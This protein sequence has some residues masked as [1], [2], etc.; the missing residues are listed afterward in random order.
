MTQP[1]TIPI[2]RDPDYLPGDRMQLEIDAA[3]QPDRIQ[4]H[5]RAREQR[6]FGFGHPSRVLFGRIVLTPD[7]FPF[8]AGEFGVGCAR[9]DHETVNRYVAG[10]YQVELTGIDVVG[11]L[12]PTSAPATIVLRTDPTAPQNLSITASVLSWTWSDP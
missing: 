2:C 1:I 11:N 7:R 3:S 12:G 6:G 10:D 4:V 8:G 9:L 5:D